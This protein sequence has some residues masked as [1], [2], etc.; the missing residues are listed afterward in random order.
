MIPQET[1]EQIRQATDISQIIG[2][3]VRLKKRGRNFTALCPFHTEK[4]PSFKVSIDKQIFH[5]FGCGK[6]GNVFTFL[7]EHEK[8]SFIEAVRFLAQRTNITIRETVSDYKREFI[9][10]LNYAHAVAVEYFHKLLFE[11]RYRV[12]LEDYLQSRRHIT[13]DSIEQFQLGLS[14][15]SWDGLIK[16]AATKDIT[17]EEL[18]KAGLAILSERKGTYFDRFRQRLMI[19]IFNL[20]G[21]PIAFGG[22]TMK[23]GEPAKYIN[24]PETP[25]YTKSNV[26]YGLNFARDHIRQANTVFVV[27]GYFDFISLW[28]AGAKNVVASSGTAFTPQQARL[29]ARFAEEVYLFFDADSAGRQAALRSV[30]ALFDSGL[31]VRVMV[32]PAGED[33]DTMAQNY[34]RESIAELKDQA[35]GFIPFRIQQIN[36]EQAGL[37]AREKLVKELASLA[38]RIGDPTRR[39]LFQQEAADKLG[40]AQA[41]LQSAVPRQRSPEE[42]PQGPRSRF[43]PHEFEL[44]SLLLHSPGS[45]D[46]AFESITTDD[47][48][49]NQLSRIYSAMKTQYENE[50]SLNTHHLIEMLR[51]DELGS[52][53]TQLAA[54]EWATEELDK[55][56]MVAINRFK[57][58]QQKLKRSALLR[59]LATAQDRGDQ[60]RA[61]EILQEMKRHGLYDAE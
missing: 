52:V 4:T 46:H 27:E 49:S 1:I 14:G 48:D 28:Q 44:L 9:E 12:V 42:V 56:T 38:S 36:L 59:E 10:R 20:S 55:E 43:N 29:L 35:L 18:S 57:A 54:T 6:G 37:I 22:R 16:Y 25:L 15:E 17:P 39:S 24:S 45:L 11:P 13:D 53:V 40:V 26:L 2:Q 19:P 60:K 33:P 3:Y 21:K 32:P 8:M 50:S 41:V 58:R 30:D 61:D 34:G 31:D 5:C 7:I 47:F 51:D 23:K